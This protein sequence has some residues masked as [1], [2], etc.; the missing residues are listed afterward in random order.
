MSEEA[1][2][3]GDKTRWVHP[4]TGCS[5]EGAGSAEGEGLRAPSSLLPPGHVLQGGDLDDV[6]GGRAGNVRGVAGAARAGSA[7]ALGR[8]RRRRG[9]ADDGCGDLGSFAVRSQPII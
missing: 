2:P 4:G 7:L 1:A 8:Q 9:D 5:K 3:L 6:G